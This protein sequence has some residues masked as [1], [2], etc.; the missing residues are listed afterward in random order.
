MRYADIF[1]NMTIALFIMGLLTFG[2]G[3]VV[4]GAYF[5]NEA[6][7]KTLFV[8]AGFAA[9]AFIMFGL[10]ARAMISEY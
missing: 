6:L 5:S 2:V 8:A 10:F 3:S 4:V 9:G 7:I 1:K